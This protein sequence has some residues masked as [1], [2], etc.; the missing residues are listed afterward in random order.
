MSERV[1]NIFNKTD[2]VP[3]A[4]TLFINKKVFEGWE[5]VQITR[6]L[7]VLA[8]DFQLKL[9]DKWKV[10]QETFSIQPGDKCHVHL[11]KKSF[12][13]GWVDS[14]AL[15]IGSNERSITAT[16]RSRTADLVDCSVTGDN[17][18]SGLNLKEIATKVCAPFNIPV[19]FLTDPGDIFD[20]ITI[21]QGETVFAL[22]DRLARQ[23]KLLMFPDYEGFL[24]FTIAGSK[25][26]PVQLIEGVNVLGGSA[27]FDNSERF[28]SYVV[29]GQNLS[30][31]GEP[32]QSAAPSGEATDEGI[33]RFRP[34]VVIGETSTDD[35]ASGD[36]AAY[37]A[38]LRAAKALEVEV[39][40]QGWL[41]SDGSPW[42]I[43][44]IV[45]CDIGSLGVRRNL[46]IKKVTFNKNNS[47]TTATL[48]LIRPDA[49]EFK[50]KVKKDKDIGWLKDFKR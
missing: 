22:L 27:T 21:Q 25:R 33:T 2:Q 44:E 36:R 37:E 38:G 10:D 42:E 19:S 48:T 32:E 13:T 17:Q 20:T 18:F 12:L 47:G 8:S 26:S 1:P 9:T 6:E 16:G 41:R 5:D 7:N 14:L 24:V 23:R 39:S 45:S 3:D 34:L 11:A 29:K 46:L 30:A 4:V 15:S 31:L 40:V 50:V 28:S 35:G 43:N 49:F